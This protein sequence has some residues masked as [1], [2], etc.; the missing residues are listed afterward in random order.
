MVLVS[1]MV[2]TC[3]TTV[4]MFA[5]HPNR[6]NIK[7][8]LCPIIKELL[9]SNYDLTHSVEYLYSLFGDKQIEKNHGMKFDFS[10]IMGAVYGVNMAWNFNVITNL[11][12]V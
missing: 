3:M 11:K 12:E 10:Q 9:A 4:N 8:I 7:F 5:T 1:P 2:R 6:Q